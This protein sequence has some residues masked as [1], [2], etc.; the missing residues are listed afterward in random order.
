MSSL[1]DA[2]SPLAL[3]S[4]A[5][6]TMPVIDIRLKNQRTFSN[7][8]NTS[9]K[10]TLLNYNL[11]LFDETISLTCLNILK[12]YY[13]LN[14]LTMKVNVKTDHNQAKQKPIVGIIVGIEKNK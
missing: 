2:K 10:A 11:F 12:T 13:Y 6:R 9:F 1:S 7:L 14:N 8:V 3:L 5:R 4:M